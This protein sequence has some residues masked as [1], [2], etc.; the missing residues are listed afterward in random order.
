MRIVRLNKIESKYE[1]NNEVYALVNDDNTTGSIKDITVYNMLLEYKNSGM[2][3]EGT[4]IIEA[5]SGNTGISLAYYQKEFNY[6]ALIVMPKSMSIERRLKIASYGAELYLT[7]GGMEESEVKAVELQKEI[8][9]SF[10]FDQFNS[11]YNALAHYKVTGPYIYNDIKDLSYIFIGIGTGGTITGTSKYLKEKNKDIKVIGIE[12]YE[13]PLI[14]KG[15]S[16]PHLI[17]GIG[18]NFIPSVLDLNYVDEVLDI[19][20]NESIETAKEIRELEKLDIGISSG[21][22]LLALITYIK[23]NNINNKKLLAI[24]PDKGDRYKW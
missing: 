22:S 21:A 10:V 18:A 23:N 7:D 4:T 17:Q 9:N 15:V 16:A 5:T 14:N 2:L 6:K 1:L 8:D 3:K 24:F 13:S 12:P 20:G 11:K 19:K